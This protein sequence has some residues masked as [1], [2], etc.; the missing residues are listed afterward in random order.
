M[1]SQAVQ[2][3]LSVV[4]G[5]VQVQISLATDQ[6]IVEFYHNDNHDNNSNGMV[7][8]IQDTIESIGYTV[9]GNVRILTTTTNTAT[10]Q[11]YINIDDNDDNNDIDNIDNM[12]DDT[13]DDTEARWQAV[14]DRQEQKVRGRQVAFLGSLCGT[15][16][17]LTL[18]MILPE[19]AVPLL[20][21]H[22]ELFHHHLQVQAVLLWVFCTPVQ[23]VAGWEFYKMAWYGIRSGRAGM[24]VL[25]ALGTSAAYLYAVTAVLTGDDVAAHFFETA[26]V[27]ISFV[28][29]GKWMQALAVRRT[30]QALT[31]LM[32]LQAKTA[33]KVTPID[34]GMDNA[35][36]FN[37]LVDPFHEAVVP[38]QQVHAGDVVKIIRGASIPA[39]GRVIAGEVSV[40]E[41]MVTGESLP[42]FKCPGSTVLGGTICVESSG[43]I[44]NYSS[45][46]NDSTNSNSNNNSNNNSNDIGAAFVRVTGV[47][48][49]TALAQIV[50]LVQ[51]AQSRSAPIQ[52][53]ADQ[54]SAVFVPT[55]C[56]VSVVTFMT[57][58]ALCSAQVVPPHWYQDLGEDPFTFSLMF[59]IA[60]LVISCPCALGLATPTAVMVGTGVGA[61]LGVLIKSGEAL[62][63]GSKVDSVVFDK[64]GTLTK[65]E[66]AITDF[67]RWGND[68]VVAVAATDS[69]EIEREVATM[70]ADGAGVD[71][72]LLWLLASLERTSEHPLAKAVVRYAEEKLDPSYLKSNPLVEPTMFRALTGR[73]ASGTVQGK[74]SVAVGN[75]SFASVLGLAIPP[76]A[77]ACMKRLEEQGKTAVLA[78]VNGSICA[79]IGIADELKA[80][81]AES[82]VYLKDVMGV[83]VWMVT[84]DNART[85]NAISRQLNLSPDRVIS[86]ALPAAKVQQV[87]KLQA[88]GRVVVMVGD[89]VNDSPALAQ[90][91]IG[92]SLGTGAEIAAEASDIVLVRGNVADVCS[93]LHLSRAIFRR[94]QWNFVWSLLYN[95]LG[96]PVAAGV[97]YPLVHTRL[98]PTVAALAMAL[99]SISVV[100]SSLSLRLYQPPIV[101]SLDTRRRPRSTTAWARSMQHRRSRNAARG[102]GGELTVN[103][104]QSDHL[105]ASDTDRTEATEIADNRSLSR[106]EEARTN[107]TI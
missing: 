25:V 14:Q 8:T 26:A 88:E 61:R 34:A 64:T 24:D 4:P 54:I 57:W 98:P 1:C 84:G 101:T 106:M 40:D 51:E 83:D 85:A 17:I 27:L 16:P 6:A 82:I 48:S 39:D 81:A 72:Y 100:F 95:C 99:S 74:V 47:G 30:S 104:L 9:E 11:N 43:S 29:A 7:E 35:S 41:S 37:P 70:G 5:I 31:Q 56:V 21:R 107:N 68:S 23:F 19:H 15:L 105:A 92:M 79:V 78:A 93:A 62:E 52:S 75:R 36:K 44:Q 42:V 67:V 46:Q 12:D 102:G 80:D 59:G 77:E 97:F 53:F 32:Q 10:T 86:E 3:A 38:I 45:Y 49:S 65:G 90:A 2:K 58:Y 71:D 33:V 91:D 13:L 20:H 96:I 89:G 63:V 22:F 18:T 94:I 66:P 73:G 60:C 28:L 69:Q 103:L 87:R 50:Q 55:V 76:Q